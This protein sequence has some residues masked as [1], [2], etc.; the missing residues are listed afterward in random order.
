MRRFAAA[1]TRDDFLACAALLNQ[2]PDAVTSRKLMDGFE[3]AFEGRV[4][5]SLPDE[6]VA[7]MMKAGGGS[8]ALRVRQND[9]A[10]L[11]EALRAM[12]DP[13][14]KQIELL[15]LIAVFGEVPHPPA[16]PVLMRLV[17]APHANV[18]S[19]ALA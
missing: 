13:K 3:A 7:A 4:L 18:R 12:A 15:R 14:M 5:P 10:A 8:L 2:A 6:L 11:E 17:R 9:P 1:G 16:A 19:A